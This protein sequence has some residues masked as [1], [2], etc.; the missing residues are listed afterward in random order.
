M[1]R[2]EELLESRYDLKPKYEDGLVM[3]RGK[4][5]PGGPTARLSNGTSWDDLASKS[6]DEIKR[7]KSFPYPPLPHPLHGN[8]GQVFPD[9]QIEMFPRLRRFDVDFDLPEAFLPEFPPA[10][11]LQNRPELGDVSRGEVI[12]INN[13]Y[14]CSKTSSHRFNWMD[15]DCC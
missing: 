9:M 2:Q 11:F 7:E 14:R 6:A 8:A 10:M 5:I 4:P 13:Y 12:S 3:T 15:C 1:N